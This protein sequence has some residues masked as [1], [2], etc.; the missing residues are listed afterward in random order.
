M[1]QFETF[2]DAELWGLLSDLSNVLQNRQPDK[3]DRAF[4]FW[5]GVYKQIETEIDR[6]L[7]EG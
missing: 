4:L 1:I 2:T 5:Y 7:R 3:S 6:R